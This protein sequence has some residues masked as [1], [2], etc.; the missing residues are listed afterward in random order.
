[1]H[2]QW[3][4]ALDSAQCHINILEI[5]EKQHPGDYTGELE[6][7]NQQISRINRILFPQ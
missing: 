1:M 7:A 4:S 6:M 3:E 5:L 2:E